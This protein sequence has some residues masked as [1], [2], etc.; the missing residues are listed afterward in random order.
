MWVGSTSSAVCTALGLFGFRNGSTR[1]VVSS[2]LSS[3]QECPWY[4]IS[5]SALSSRCGFA[6]VSRRHLFSQCPADGDANHHPH[7]RLL[8]EQGPDRGEALLGVGYGRRPQGLGLV[9]LPK[10]ASL[11]E[12]GGED[13]LQLRGRLGDDPL[14]LGEALRVKQPLDRRLQLLLVRHA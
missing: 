10:P 8:G 7:P 14:G 5:I 2:S 6:P 1:T 13:L 11:G 4:L 12:R 3:K 9:R